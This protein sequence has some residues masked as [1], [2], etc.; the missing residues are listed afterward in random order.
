MKNNPF[1]TNPA[2]KYRVIDK[3]G[4]VVETF[5]TKQAARDFIRQNRKYFLNELKI[6]K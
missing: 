2:D 3:K 6:S 5:R 4:K 1:N